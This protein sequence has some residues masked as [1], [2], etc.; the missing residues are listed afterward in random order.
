MN[1]QKLTSSKRFRYGT[2]SVAFSAVFVAVILIVNIIVSALAARFPLHVDMT[3]EAL[4]TL[5]DATREQL[6]G[7]DAGVEIVFFNKDDKIT[8]SYLGYVNS[9]AK[10][11]DKAFDFVTVKYIDLVSS[12]AAA[13]KYK[14]TGAD[15]ITQNT[16]V[17]SCPETGKSRIIQLR[18]FYTFLQDGSGN[19]SST[20]YGFNGE[21]RLTANIL[22]VASDVRPTALFTVGH[23]ETA[24]G[25]LYTLLSGEGYDVKTVNLM[26]EEI[27]PETDLLIISNPMRDF[28]GLSA[29]NNGGKNEIRALNNYLMNDYGNVLVFLSP[30]TPELPE[31]S[32]YLAEWGVSYAKGELLQDAPA[33]TID[34]QGVQIVASYCG[35]ADS[36]EYQLHRAVSGGSAS[37]R[38]VS[39]YNVPLTLSEVSDKTV[40]P[41]LAASDK[42]VRTS[43]ENSSPAPNAPL[44]SL[45]SYARYI[46]N[47]EVRANMLVFASPYFFDSAYISSSVYGNA[48]ILYSA[49]KLFGNSAVSVNIPTKPFADTSLDITA[50]SATTA[51]VILSAVIPLL[52]L[53]FGIFVWLKRKAK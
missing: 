30:Q 17:V 39:A 2:M 11:Y 7:I 12:P 33:N 9:L 48:E 3:S 18:G 49:M 41:V 5:S 26:T 28:A 47:E 32:E 6:S 44:L 1:I 10:E 52:L 53:A 21:K 4:Y 31:L 19:T 51:A 35:D 16:V 22:Q 43:G 46:D 34:T 25:N 13:N 42:A 29:E 36:Y 27:P 24:S 38:T 40:V 20:P 23:D 37:A 14:M 15:T 8:E 50:K 45:S